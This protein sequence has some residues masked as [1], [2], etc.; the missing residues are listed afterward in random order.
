MVLSSDAHPLAHEARCRMALPTTGQP[1]PANFLLKYIDNLYA[2]RCSTAGASH[3]ALEW[4]GYVG[5]STRLGNQGGTP[6][7]AWKNWK[8]VVA[9][10]VLRLQ[11]VSREA[12][13][14]LRLALDLWCLL[15]S[16]HHKHD[17]HDMNSRSCSWCNPQSA[18]R[19]ARCKA[20]RV[21]FFFVHLQIVMTE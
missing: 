10:A 6:S 1:A 12:V 5:E 21:K 2:N 8:T 18:S 16:G 15:R 7:Q 9:L 19:E 14:L 17:E 4:S 20:A 3:E 13:E 11:N